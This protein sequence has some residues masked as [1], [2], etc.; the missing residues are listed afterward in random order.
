MFFQF[1]VPHLIFRYT[2][3]LKSSGIAERAKLFKRILYSLRGLREYA[4]V[5]Y[6]SR[7]ICQKHLIVFRERAKS[8]KRKGKRADF[9]VIF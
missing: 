2:V 4:E 3:R 5:F 1:E 6:R 7:R 8:P 9:R